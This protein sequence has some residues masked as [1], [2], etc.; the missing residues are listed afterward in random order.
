MYGKWPATEQT[1]LWVAVAGISLMDQ[2][3]AFLKFTEARQPVVSMMASQMA[4][5]ITA[6]KAAGAQ[7]R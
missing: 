2:P 3:E 5:A 1:R 4:I 6:A 7:Q